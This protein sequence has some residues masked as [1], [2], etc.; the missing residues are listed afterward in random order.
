MKEIWYG[1]RRK[2]SKIMIV[3]KEKVLAQIIQVMG[4]DLETVDSFKYLGSNIIADGKCSEE[5]CNRLAMATSSLMNFSNLWQNSNI[6][7]KTKYRLLTTITR[8]VAPYGCKSW[9]LNVALQERLNAF[10]MK[11]Y[12]KLLQIPYTAHRTNESVKQELTQKAGKVEM[13]VSIIKKRQLKWFGH[14]KRHNDS[15]LLANNIMH[16]R[17]PGRRGRGRPRVT[18]IQNNRDYTGLWAEAVT[19]AQ[20]RTD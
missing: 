3:G 9:T 10:E 15:L 11:C 2:K 5:V 7:I 6:S 20:D 17:V 12:R 19:A 16:G 4:K 8:A 14:V 18:W 13:L 1:N